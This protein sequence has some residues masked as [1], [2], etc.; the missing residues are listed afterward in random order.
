[1]SRCSGSIRLYCEIPMNL[2]VISNPESTV[3]AMERERRTGSATAEGV[4]AE[5]L[6]RTVATSGPYG[7]WI[8]QA[9]HE[10]NALRR[11]REAVV[12]RLR[13]IA[14]GLGGGGEPARV[15]ATAI[16]G[17]VDL[18]LGFRA[19]LGLL[20]SDDPTTLSQAL[21]ELQSV[22]IT[23]DEDRRG[24]A[25]LGVEPAE[26]ARMTSLLDHPDEKVV[27][28]TI[29]HSCHVSMRL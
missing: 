26:L 29:W 18:P 19:L 15:Y 8:H 3:G 6:A 5:I 14:D 12:P 17:R 27:G 16:L 28:A 24:R 1:M 7:P 25:D 22:V 9:E 20:E 23:A 13:A 21:N 2:I 11:H 4:F 10:V